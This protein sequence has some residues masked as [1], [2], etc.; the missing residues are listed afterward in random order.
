MKRPA[1]W[2]SI[3]IISAAVLALQIVL[4]RALSI[5]GYY[6]FAYLI[7]GTALLGFGAS[8]TALSLL[9]SR[10][11]DHIE[12]W[13][14]R[15][16]G[17]FVISSAASY[18]LAMAV[19]PDMQYLLYD[20]GQAGRMALEIFLLF[21]PFF[22]AGLFVGLVLSSFPRKAGRLY[23]ANLFGSG[24]GALVGVGTLFLVPAVDLPQGLALLGIAAFGLWLRYMRVEA[25][26]EASAGNDAGK[27]SPARSRRKALIWF[28]LAIV[29]GAG[30]LFQARQSGVEYDQYKDI[31]QLERLEEQGSA[32]HVARTCGPRGQID[33]YEAQ[34]LHSTLFASPTGSPPPPQ[35]SLFNDG[36]AAGTIFRIDSDD[37]ADVLQTVPQSIPYRLRPGARVLLLGETGG[38]NVWLARR[39]DA[40]KITVVQRNPQ[41]IRLMREELSAESGGVY[42]GPDVTVVSKDPRLYLQQ[43]DKEFD[44]IQFVGAEAL[45]AGSG[46]MGS[47]SQ[48]YLLTREAF[49]EAYTRLAEGGLI[50]VTRGIHLPPRDNIRI[51]STLSAGIEGAAASAP[52]QTENT[53]PRDSPLVDQTESGRPAASKIA[54]MRNYLAVTTIAARTALSEDDKDHIKQMAGPLQLDIV[55]LPGT[56]WGSRE[57]RNRLPGPEGKPYSYYHHA[58][59]RILEAGEASRADRSLEGP[60]S[61][62]AKWQPNSA[63]TF[64]ET[65]YE[66][67]VYNVRPATDDKPYFHSFFKWSS[68]ENYTESYGRDWFRRIDL[69]YAVVTLTFVEVTVLAVVLVLVPMLFYRHRSGGHRSS[70]APRTCGGRREQDPLKSR[71]N[72]A[73][74]RSLLEGLLHFMGIGFAFMFFEIL[75]IQ[76]L[77]QFMGDPVYSTAAVLTGIL[78]FAGGGSALQHRLAPRPGQRVL[79]AGLIL[80]ALG[81]V[82]LLGL[83]PL[84]QAGVEMPTAGRFTLTLAL[85]FPVSFV[86]GVFFPAG[87]AYMRSKD[88]DFVPLMWAANGVASVSATPLALLL[89]MT[90]GFRL[91]FVGAVCLYLLVAL[92][93]RRWTE[94]A[95]G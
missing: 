91:V 39:F 21:L 15:A 37:K 49:G 43:T 67:W 11:K 73:R 50:A 16:I 56:Q 72:P 23:A 2:T 63:G 36:N 7:I 32:E 4:L 6:H 77:T 65:F 34:T 55:Y 26:E 42:Q 9:W 51:L 8:G 87:I 58:A 61:E 78:V 57:Q 28:V 25:S 27:A 71:L 64:P 33:V 69:G 13:G 18:P 88:P 93:A 76:R 44:I 66:D 29:V 22:F 62:S 59:L 52:A 24:V 92:S 90:A 94:E 5:T 40:S 74:R 41:L 17:L 53:A 60:A 45:P 81:L 89:S 86:L 79:R 84:L 3:A 82:Y 48:D 70:L 12:L 47:L 54:V 83:D 19:R 35:L 85:L 10:I 68:L 95:A 31:A 1:L 38:V 14:A 30:G 20:F 46:A 75:L 80:A